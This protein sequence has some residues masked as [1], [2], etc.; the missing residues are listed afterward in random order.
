MVAIGKH[1]LVEQGDKQQADH[2]ADDGCEHHPRTDY[3]HM[4]LLSVGIF[5][6]HLLGE[7]LHA[8]GADTQIGGC[9]EH[10][11]RA[12]KERHKPHHGGSQQNSNNLIAQQRNKN[13]DALYTAEQTGIFQYLSVTA[14]L[15][16]IFH[17]Q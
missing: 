14:C 7:G 6:L 15:V 2:E 1:P 9:G 10:L 5:L 3:P 16:E 8:A 13:V 12:V 4:T 11:Q 17:Y